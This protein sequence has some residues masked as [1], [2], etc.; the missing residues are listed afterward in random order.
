MAPSRTM[1]ARVN[2]NAL[3]ISFLKTT[4]AREPAAP[5][6]KIVSERSARRVWL[7]RIWSFSSSTRCSRSRRRTAYVAPST[8]GLSGIGTAGPL[9]AG[10]AEDATLPDVAGV[11][12]S[13]VLTGVAAPPSFATP[14]V[15]VAP[16]PFPDAAPAAGCWADALEIENPAPPRAK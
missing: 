11:A 4:S 3:D 6:D 10:A 14:A 5:P 8:A 9:P 2:L 1:T 12:F 7:R 13:V 16:T 15:V